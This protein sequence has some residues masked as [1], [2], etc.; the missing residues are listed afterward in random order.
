MLILELEV[1]CAHTVSISSKSWS[2]VPL[3]IWSFEELEAAADSRVHA[4]HTLNAGV[5]SDFLVV[6]GQYQPTVTLAPG[7]SKLFRS[8]YGEWP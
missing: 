3:Q 4:D 5:P 8:V 2:F 7:Q 6:N 1:V